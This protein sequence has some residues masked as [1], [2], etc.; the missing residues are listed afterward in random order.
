MF[1]VRKHFELNPGENCLARLISQLSER[2]GAWRVA[3]L[4]WAR[5]ET[6][7]EA[8]QLCWQPGSAAHSTQREKSLSMRL[9]LGLRMAS[10]TEL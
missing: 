8:A 4:D 1:A 9:S 6:V 7:L 10:L 3:G 5:L 2:S